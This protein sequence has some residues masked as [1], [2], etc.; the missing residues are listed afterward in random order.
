MNQPDEVVK[1]YLKA[2]E[3]RDADAFAALFAADAVGY[4]PLFDG[5][6][7]GRDAIRAGE[8]AVFDAFSDVAV[9]ARSLLGDGSRYAIEVVLTAVNT[10]P[11]DM[12]GGE[13]LPATGRT[14]EL[15]ATWWLELGEDGLIVEARDY[16]DTATLMRQ[17]G[18]GDV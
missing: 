5:P 8:Q 6:V 12:G 17:L 1:Q 7:R 11:L 14:I 18:L 13:P 3:A 9:T 10:G 4:H 2:I 16:L 15:P